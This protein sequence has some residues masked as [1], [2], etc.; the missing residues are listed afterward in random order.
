VFAATRPHIEI[1]V[2][3]LEAERHLAPATV[4]RRLCMVI[5][6]AYY[7]NKVDAGKGKKGA[8]RCLKRRLSD[9]V[10]RQ[11]VAEHALRSPGG[12]MGATLTSSAAD[13]IPM[14]NTSEKPQ[15]GLN[16]DHTPLSA[17]A[18]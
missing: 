6:L 17:A 7:A 8:M 2:R 4:A 15:P 9:V 3:W 14:A 12:Q 5:G 10:Y 11:L 1:Y 13:L 16:T 18:S